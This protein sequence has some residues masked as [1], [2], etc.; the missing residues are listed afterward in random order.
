MLVSL[1][2]PP[3]PRPRPQ[4]TLRPRLRAPA[5]QVFFRA[6]FCG[7]AGFLVSLLPFLIVAAAAAYY[8][9]AF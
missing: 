8:A 4:F 7:V 3:I 6:R 5:P 1:T 2:T 9:F